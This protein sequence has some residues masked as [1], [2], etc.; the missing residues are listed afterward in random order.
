LNIRE[1][2]YV[3]RGIEVVTS[4]NYGVLKK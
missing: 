4:S 1:I 3:G 2:L